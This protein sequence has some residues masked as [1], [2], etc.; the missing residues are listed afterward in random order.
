MLSKAIQ[1]AKGDEEKKVGVSLKMAETFRN[2]LQTIAD[3]NN[4]SLNALII[5][6]LETVFEAKEEKTNYLDRYNELIEIIQEC[7]ILINK[8]ADESDVGFNPYQRRLIANN[9]IK[10]IADLIQHEEENL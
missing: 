1:K 9:E 7:D 10:K 4:V 5:G 6:M 3:K 2:K 8:G